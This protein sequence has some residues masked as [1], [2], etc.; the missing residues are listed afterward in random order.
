MMV[1]VLIKDE[2][3]VKAE[4][5]AWHKTHYR[6]EWFVGRTLV[7]GILV[8]AL[9][10]YFFWDATRWSPSRNEMQIG[11]A[12][13]IALLALGLMFYDF[14]VRLANETWGDVFRRI[15]KH[16]ALSVLTFLI[17]LAATLAVHT[18]AV[19]IA[20]EISPIPTPVII[21]QAPIKQPIPTVTVIKS[22]PPAKKIKAPIKPPA[23]TTL[24]PKP[25]RL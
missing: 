13:W 20:S 3:L 4:A 22:K 2:E 1:T 6:S 5:E 9:A 19:G 18:A 21:T 24:K 12:V 7:Y 11:S 17:A 23:S 10:I 16:L 8:T 15:H 14:R 25:N